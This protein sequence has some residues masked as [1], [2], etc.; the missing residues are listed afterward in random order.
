MRSRHTSLSGMKTARNRPLKYIV[1][2]A[3]TA[4]A[5][6]GCTTT[7]KFACKSPDGVSCMSAPELYELTNGPGA[8]AVSDKGMQSES[9]RA[10]RERQSG[11]V[12]SHQVGATGDALA[13]SAPIQPRTGAVREQ[14]LSLSPPTVGAEIPSGGASS[15][16]RVPAKVMRI[17]VAPWTDVE[18]D[19]HMPGYV[20]SEITTRRWS[21]GGDVRAAANAPSSFDP[22]GPWMTPASTPS[23]H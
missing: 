21:I 9:R 4:I 13:L 16:A 22:N 23:D 14:A 19:L 2:A 15:I 1:A 5:L 3:V 7:G 8:G 20:Y 12:V 6:T 11:K 18:G 17:W 10:K